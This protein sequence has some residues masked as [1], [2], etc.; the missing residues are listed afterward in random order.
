[1]DLKTEPELVEEICRDVFVGFPSGNGQAI[2]LGPQDTLTITEEPLKL[3]ITFGRGDT[4]VYDLRC[5]GFYRIA[6]IT[7]RVLPP[8]TGAR[9]AAGSPEGGT[10]KPEQTDEQAPRTV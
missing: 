9:S 2:L 10:A 1:M 7:R 8:K 4:E 6:H 5:G 3:A